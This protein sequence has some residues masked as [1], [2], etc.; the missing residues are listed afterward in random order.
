MTAASTPTPAGDAARPVEPRTLGSDDY[1]PVYVWSVGAEGGNPDRADSPL[2]SALVDPERH[3]H[4]SYPHQE[5]LGWLSLHHPDDQE[6]VFQRWRRTLQTGEPADDEYRLRMSDGSYRWFR[7]VTRAERDGEGRIVK[8]HGASIDIEAQKQLDAA[9]RAREQELTQLVDMVPS[10]VWRLR[11]DGEPVFFNRRRVDDLG[12]DV[13]DIPDAGA[14]R[15]AAMIVA[16]VHPEDAREFEARLRHSLASGEVFT[17]RY[18]LRRRDATHR[19]MSSRA[20]PMRDAA[21]E[22]VQWYG[23]CHD[24]DE[25]MRAEDALRRSERQMREII[26]AVP[27]MITRVTPDGRMVYVNRRFTEVTG[28]TLEALSEADGWRTLDD[29]H[30]DDRDATN[31]IGPSFLAGEPYLVR[32]RQKRADGTYRW[33]EHRASPLR[34]ETGRVADWYGLSVDIDDLVRAEGQLREQA[35]ELARA[36]RSASLAELSASI[37]HEV[38]QPMA[39]IVTNAQ[40]GLRWLSA[41]PPNIE[42]AVLSIERIAR[43]A[44]SAAD[45]VNRVR[46]LFRQSSQ[47]RA[48][49]DVNELI[50]DVCRLM[51]DEPAARGVRLHETVLAPGLPPALIDRVQVQQVMVNLIRNALDAMAGGGPEPRTLAIRSGRAGARMIRV[52]VQDS[53][54]GFPDAERALDP[55][56]TTKAHGMGMGLAICRTIIE[57]HGGRLTVANPSG[58]GALVAFTL[59]LAGEPSDQG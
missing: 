28:V 21:G 1:V 52:E 41:D 24:I 8:W 43:D 42:R 19:W 51:A 22:I 37:A 27:G 39:A 35:D 16:S 45:V 49:E 4:L 31:A 53:G 7:C 6:R 26:D 17:T 57:D 23:V 34:D 59:P 3:T 11:P 30:P 38:N 54:P 10:H 50:Q 58:G 46:A 5:E 20:E 13:A 9:L 29:V 2:T 44:D 56:F 18:R 55:F 33:T 15:L 36:S 32:F 48:A 47:V 40:A 12:F 25:Q 14:T